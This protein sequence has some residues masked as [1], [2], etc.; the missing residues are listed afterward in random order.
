VGRGVPLLTGIPQQKFFELSSKKF[1]VLGLGIFFIVK[2]NGG[3][4]PGQG[5]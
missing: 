4:K 5:A 2:M 1:R 3:R